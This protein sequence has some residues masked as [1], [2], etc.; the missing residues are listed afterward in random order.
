[1]A[2]RFNTGDAA[3]IENPSY[4]VTS[5]YHWA[6]YITCLLVF[7]VV[8][9]VTIINYRKETKQLSKEIQRHRDELKNQNQ[10]LSEAL[11][12]VKTLSGLL[13]ICSYCKKIRD[14][15]G[16]WTRIESY[17]QDHSEAEFSHSLCRECAKKHYPEINIYEE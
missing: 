8:A 7:F 3:I 5:Y 12:N 1:M 11:A 15:K 14:D 6:V 13:P 16:Y 9:T 2:V 4:F 10:E 17:I